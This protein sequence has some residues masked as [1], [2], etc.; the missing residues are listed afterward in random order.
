MT[1]QAWEDINIDA[2][3]VAL[4]KSYAEE[5]GLPKAQDFP[6]DRSKGIYYINGY[7]NLHCLVGP[8]H[9][10]SEHDTIK[11]TSIKRKRSDCPTINFALACLKTWTSAISCIALILF[12]KTYSATPMMYHDT[13]DFSLRDP[14]AGGRSTNVGIGI[15]WKNGQR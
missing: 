14:L 9:P 7:H 6:W 10:S 1:D 13:L 2:G 5:M 15:N 12:D 8:S 11:L 3:N 4:D